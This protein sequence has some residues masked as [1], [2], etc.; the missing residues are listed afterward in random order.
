MTIGNIASSILGYV[1]SM[2]S[3]DKLRNIRM[4]H[5]ESDLMLIVLITLVL[6]VITILVESAVGL[7][8]RKDSSKKACIGS[9]TMGN[10]VTYLGIS[11]FAF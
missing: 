9:I 2:M 8:M 6:L 7:F 3:S 10:M 4:D 11:L 1:L 5:H